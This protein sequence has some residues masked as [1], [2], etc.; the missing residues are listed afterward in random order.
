L[1]AH[2]KWWEYIWWYTIAKCKFKHWWLTITPISIKWTTNHLSSQINTFTI[3]FKVRICANSDT[4]MICN[5]FLGNFS[6]SWH[7]LIDRLR[8]VEMSMRPDEKPP[9]Q[10]GMYIRWHECE[11]C[12]GFTHYI[13]E[14]YRLSDME[15]LLYLYFYSANWQC[16]A[17]I[18]RSYKEMNRLNYIQYIQIQ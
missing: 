11:L 12:S 13:I 10:V 4:I 5:Y 1:I 16:I 7:S 17:H 6:L 3:N 18:Q 2:M 14:H 8:P 15:I 9:N